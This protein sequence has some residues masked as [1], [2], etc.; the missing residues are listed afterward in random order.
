MSPEML[1]I[2]TIYQEGSFSRAAS[3]LY[4]SQ[5]ALSIAIRKIENEIGMPL[6]DRQ[7]KPLRLTAA[8]EIYIDTIKKELL[9]EQEQQQKI[10]DLKNLTSGTVRL[11]GTH[12]LNAYILPEVLSDFSL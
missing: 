8:G 10:S 7:S 5:P 6:F 2:Y 3:K 12:F 11:G 9:L 4:L 1:Y